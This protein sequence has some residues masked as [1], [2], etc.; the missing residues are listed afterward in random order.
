MA[1]TDFVNESGQALTELLISSLILFPTL[2]LVG[3]F[4]RAQWN[5]ARCAYS[6]FEWTHSGLVQSQPR[7]VRPA[8]RFRIH[9]FSEKIQGLGTCGPISEKTVLYR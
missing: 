6:V 2:A 8:D 9:E 7:N 1:R 5:Q 4:L 3:F